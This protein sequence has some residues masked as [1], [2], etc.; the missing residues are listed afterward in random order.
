MK[1]GIDLSRWQGDLD[2]ANSGADFVIIKAGGS[3]DGLYI[4]SQFLNS[5]IKCKNA[6]IP[7]GIYWYSQAVNNISLDKEISFLTDNIKGLQ[8]EYPV[9]LDLE[10]IV[11]YDYIADLAMEWVNAWMAAGYYPG[12]YSSYSWWL[13]NM[14]KISSILPA[15]QKWV[16]LWDEDDPGMDCG[17]WQNGITVIN[18]INTDSDICYVDYSFIREQGLNGFSKGPAFSDVPAT[19][20]GYK[21]IMWAAGLG[22][23]KGY[24]D[25]TF[26]PEDPVTRE[27][28]CIILKRFYDAV[29]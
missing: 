15:D 29:Y 11:Q 24:P 2:I 3:D 7:C 10:E 14:S 17:I 16:A 4:D 27:Q 9:F 20:P 8:F 21:A 6:G 5:Y 26:R 18:G 13:G 22:L 25:G 12:I 23:V 28:L 1:T 19:R